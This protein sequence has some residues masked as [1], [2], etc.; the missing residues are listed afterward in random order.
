MLK[1]KRAY[2]KKEPDDGQRIL[3]DRLWPRGVKKSEAEIDEWLKELGPSTQLRKWFAH[4]PQKWPE[5]KKRYIAEL[6]DHHIVELLEN[7]AQESLAD[8]V[9]LIYGAKD[10]EHNNARVLEELI[11]KIVKR[12]K[13]K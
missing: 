9:T 7:I 5:F 2:E 8:N 10:T 3:I 12:I 4:D 11:K 1:V 13:K 6:S